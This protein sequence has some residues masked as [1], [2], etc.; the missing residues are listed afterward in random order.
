LSERR[1]RDLKQASDYFR[2]IACIR[3]VSEWMLDTHRTLTS[4]LNFNDLF[5][6]TRAKQEHDNLSFEMSQRDDL[7]KCLEEMCLQ[8]TGGPKT[9]HPNKKDIILRTNAA[10]I[11]RENLFRLWD[12]KNKV[13]EAQYDCQEFYRD[14]N[15][16]IGV[17]NS[18]DVMVSKAYTELEAGL[19]LEQPRI[20]VDD[21]ESLAKTNDNL[22]KKLD[23]QS[24]EKVNDLQ[25]KGSI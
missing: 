19:A 25:K 21:L 14:A 7:F 17:I 13:L 5:S 1:T 6:V 10:M 8:L 18:M 4:P 16:V 20:T 23:K 3:D 24:Q 22:K 12:L 9:P 2:F 15:Q 11:E